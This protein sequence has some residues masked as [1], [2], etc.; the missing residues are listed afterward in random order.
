MT[1]FPKTTVLL[2]T[3]DTNVRE[4]RGLS[5]VAECVLCVLSWILQFAYI[6][7]LVERL[8]PSPRGRRPVL[9]VNEK[10]FRF[11]SSFQ[12]IVINYL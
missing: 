11:C 9:L 2:F 5:E 8:T 10:Y 6:A 7:V 3:L 4:D 12:Y 1:L